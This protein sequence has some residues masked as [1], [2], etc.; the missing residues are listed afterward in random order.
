MPEPL[1]R[2]DLKFY[3]EPMQNGIDEINIHLKELNSKTNRNITDI[4]ILYDRAEQAR[5]I[6][7]QSVKDA[8]QL[9]LTS[10][11]EAKGAGRSSGS[12]Y[13]AAVGTAVASAVVVIW[14][15]VT[16]N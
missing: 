15:W 1:T 11:E 2:E 16:K 9:A 8:Q 4:A 5:E 6:A 3:M 12:K 14:Q 10:K 7:L 13:G